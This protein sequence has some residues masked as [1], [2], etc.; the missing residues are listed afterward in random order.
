MLLYLPGTLE[1]MGR[2]W[3][4]QSLEM[5]LD[6]IR[7]KSEEILCWNDKFTFQNHQTCLVLFSEMGYSCTHLVWPTIFLGEIYCSG[8]AIKVQARFP[9]V[10]V[11]VPC[12]C[13]C[14][15]W[16]LPFAGTLTNYFSDNCASNKVWLYIG[17]LQAF[18]GVM[19]NLMHLEEACYCAIKQASKE[20]WPVHCFEPKSP[21]PLLY[22]TLLT[23]KVRRRDYNLPLSPEAKTQQ[24]S[25]EVW[26]DGYPFSFQPRVRY[27]VLSSMLPAVEITILEWVD[28]QFEPTPHW[29]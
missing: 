23:G 29:V 25:R 8:L 13:P 16:I 5:P 10:R 1:Q 18:R 19:F 4:M 20:D 17:V 3:I 6:R 22:H 7:S 26:A 2:I 21:L 14:H 15:Y 12:R 24:I 11:W 28:F 9:S 27:S